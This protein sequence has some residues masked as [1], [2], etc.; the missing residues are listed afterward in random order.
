MV[1]GQSEH[2]RQG[3]SKSGSQSDDLSA[4]LQHLKS[5]EGVNMKDPNE[6]FAYI[7]QLHSEVQIMEEKLLKAHDLVSQH[8]ELEDQKTGRRA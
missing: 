2:S 7:E 8:P 3:K 1:E 5:P 4:K 6:R